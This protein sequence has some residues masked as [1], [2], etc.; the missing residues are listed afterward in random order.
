[1][2]ILAINLPAFH[3]IKENDEW[4]G[5]GFTE[6]DNVKSGKKYYEGHIQ[7]V[8]PINE[9]YYDLSKMEDISRQIELANEYG[10]S[11]F[12]F[13][14]YW[15]GN[16]KMLFE[17]PVEML[18]DKKDEKIEYC[19]CWAN[20]TWKTTW[21]GKEPKELMPQ[22]YLG[23]ED[24]KEHIEYL[25]EFFKDE[26]YIKIDERPVMFIYKPNEII[27]YNEMID[28]WNQYL[29]DNGMKKVYIIEYVCSKNKGLYS[30]KSDAVFEFEPL[31]STF[32]D[33][34]NI[35]KA[36]R[37][38]CKSLKI[39]DYQNYDNLWKKILK[40]KRTYKGKTIYKGCF[41]AWDNSPRKEK[42]SMIIKNSTPE[43]FETYLRQLVHTK[44]KDA[45]Q[46][47]LI[48]NAWNEWSEGAMLE[49]TEHLQYRYLEAV[50]NV[51]NEKTEY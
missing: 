41:C 16:K 33:I 23:K 46:D 44:R 50:R 14:H 32:F 25:I 5:E 37:A 18:K 34:S 9:Y 51:V 31:Y 27:H 6:W 39:I 42:N 20:E 47:Y 12:V 43:K 30:M 48:I 10:V 26:R 28:Y 24:W 35:N 22:L 7:P 19:F 1:M 45:S 15:F 38:I 4:W 36:K 11:G 8:K 49:P 2:K 3:R 13:Y 17:K 40:R 21:H 29:E